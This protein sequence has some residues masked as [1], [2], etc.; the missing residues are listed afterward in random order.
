MDQR[1]VPC[2]RERQRPVKGQYASRVRLRRLC[3][4]GRGARDRLHYDPAA[5]AYDQPPVRLAVSGLFVIEGRNGP[6]ACRPAFDLYAAQCRAMS[7]EIAARLSG[8]DGE[9]IRA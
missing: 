7:T 3:R 6:I 4:L 1:T 9:A 2:A 5:R 8:V